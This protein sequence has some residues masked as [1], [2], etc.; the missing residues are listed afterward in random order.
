MSSRELT[1]K[2]IQD[3]ARFLSGEMDEAEITALRT[4]LIKDLSFR[5]KVE[6]LAS[7]E[8]SLSDALAVF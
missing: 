2:E 4:L 6:Q 3:L 7:I 5:K 1:E 8:T